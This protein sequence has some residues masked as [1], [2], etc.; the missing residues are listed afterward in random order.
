VTNLNKAHAGTNFKMRTRRTGPHRKGALARAHANITGSRLIATDMTKT[1]IFSALLALS[2]S[3]CNR[4]ATTP[5]ATGSAATTQ[6][7]AGDKHPAK[8]AKRSRKLTAEQLAQVAA[9]GKTGLW[10][11]TPDVCRRRAARK[12]LTLMWNVQAS[13]AKTVALYLVQR[14]GERRV[15]RGDAIGGH[16]VGKWP[17]PGTTFLLRDP[18]NKTELG[19]LVLGAKPC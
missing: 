7:S 12:P 14:N 15:G 11:D 2:V 6:A 5:A 16:V 19:K 9:S 13:G 4:P 18:D 8:P 1:L 3:A 10:S 17:R